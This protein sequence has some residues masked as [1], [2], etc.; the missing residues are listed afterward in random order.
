MLD[1][2]LDQLA[3]AY[4]VTTV[5]THIQTASIIDRLIPMEDGA[6]APIYFKYRLTTAVTTSAS[7][8]WEVQ[9]LGNATDPTFGSGNVVLFDSLTQAASV[10]VKGYGQCAPIPR[11]PFAEYEAIGTPLRYYAFAVIIATGALT[12]GAWSAWL[13]NGPYQDNLAYAAGYS[14]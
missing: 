13:T 8:T 5:A 11:Q 7:G 6:G 1:D 2:F 9:L 4:A 3:A 14:A 10:G 12:A